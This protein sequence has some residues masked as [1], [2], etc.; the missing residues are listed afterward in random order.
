[1][2]ILLSVICTLL[3]L[4][5]IGLIL[6]YSGRINVGALQEPSALTRWVLSSAMDNSVEYHSK[7]I[8]VPGLENESMIREGAKHYIEMCVGCHGAPGTEDSEMARGLEPGAPHLYSTGYSKDFEPAEAFWI[9]KNGIMM[10][11][12]PAWGKT[13]SDEKIWDMVAFLKKLPEISPG[14]Y[15]QLAGELKA[16]SAEAGDEGGANAQN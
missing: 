15:N 13:H 6:I 7:D 14:E 3:G 9:I 12:M 10:T 1:M 2:K 16:E 4:F 8:E 5:L 11:S